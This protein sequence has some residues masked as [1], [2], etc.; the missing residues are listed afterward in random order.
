[1]DGNNNG[2]LPLAKSQV[3]HGNVTGTVTVTSPSRGNVV[4]SRV[5][6]EREQHDTVYKGHCRLKFYQSFIISFR[7]VSFACSSLIFKQILY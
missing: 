4:L 7:A 3:R 5:D 2:L 1:M 6:W